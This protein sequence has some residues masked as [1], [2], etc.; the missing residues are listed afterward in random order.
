MTLRAA[1]LAPLLATACA[2]APAP[3]QDCA[4]WYRELDAR[5]ERGGVRDAQARPV[6]GYPYLRVDRLLASLREESATSEPKAR[7]LVARMQALDVE[8]RGVEL[9]NLGLGGDEA[10]EALARARD[11]GARLSEADVSDPA[12]RARLLERAG[13]PDDYSTAARFFGIYALTRYPFF[14]GVR[15]Y[16]D[17]VRETFRTEPGHAA[18]RYAPPGSQTISRAE[19]AAALAKASPNPLGIPEPRREALERLFAAHA[20]VF[21]IEQTGPFDRPGALRWMRGG[22]LPSVD[23]GEPAVYRMAS[24]TRY[25]GRVLLQLVYTIWFSG[26]PADSP[27]DLLS[28]ALDGVVWRVTLA[29]DGEPLIYDTMHPCGCY[30]MFF[31]TPRA[32]PVPSPDRVLE[33]AFSPQ[34]LP[35]VA[36]DERPVLRIAT[37]THYVE[38][39]TLEREDAVETRYALRPYDELRSMPRPEG[40]RASAFGQ[41]G[42]IGGTERAER[43]F[44]WPMGIASPGAMRQWGRHATAFVG[45]RHFDD[46]DLLEKRFVLELRGAA[47]SPR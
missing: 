9:A 26:R 27:F 20:P 45:R 21:E 34:S 29:P 28:G 35:R 32:R 10:R 36:E 41:D 7:A 18:R 25:R 5:V 6:A 37:R 46:A 15:N 8:G 39:V 31:P 14:A 38:R 43:F 22:E 11:C 12:A 42:I 24:W 30:H 16:Q 17:G 33:W 3:P 13:V 4:A 40:G 1:W 19:Q 2:T 23:A 47:Y 44:F